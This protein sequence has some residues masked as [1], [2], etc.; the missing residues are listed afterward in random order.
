MATLDLYQ[1]FTVTINGIP[2]T[3]GSM[4]APDQITLGDE[5]VFWERRSIAA[6]ATWDAWATGTEEP[7]T[8]FDFL[9]CESNGSDVVIELTTDKGAEVGTEVYTYQLTADVPFI[10]TSDDSYANYTVDFAGGTLDVIDQIRIK[11]LNASARIVTLGLF[12]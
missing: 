3:M 6:S 12:S 11:N 2:Y 10:L 7:L 9:C 5:T 1:F 4:A 8:D